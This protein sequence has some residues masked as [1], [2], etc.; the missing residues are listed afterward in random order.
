MTVVREVGVLIPA[1][2]E[3]YFKVS[4][5]LAPSCELSY[6]QVHWLYTV[7]HPHSYVEVKMCSTLISD[8]NF[9]AEDLNRLYQYFPSAFGRNH[10]RRFQHLSELQNRAIFDGFK[11]ELIWWVHQMLP[12]KAM[13]GRSH[14]RPW[15]SADCIHDQFGNWSLN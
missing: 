13:F 10:R 6:E 3:S 14:S 12:W 1:M 2:T 4:A 7:E 5:P 9:Y 15:N 8:Q 11:I